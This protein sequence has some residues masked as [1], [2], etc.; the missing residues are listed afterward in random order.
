[1]INDKP[2][3]AVIGG[4]GNLGAAIATGLA[5]AGYPIVI[6][7]RDAARAVSAAADMSAAGDVTGAGNPG[8]AEKGDIVILA[9]PFAHQ[10]ATLG[11]I[12][13]ALEGKLVVETTVPLVPPKV[14]RVQLPAEGSAAVRAQAMLGDGVTVTSA[15]HT[16]SAHALTDGTASGDVLVFGDKR[17]A[18]DRVVELVDALGLRGIHGGGLAN[19]AAAE[20]MTSVLIFVNRLYGAG[21]AGLAITGDV[22]APRD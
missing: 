8:A 17:A 2:T 5:K 12:R 4:T 1:M 3:I 6:G 11:A 15:F 20:A 21:G 18:R 14:A 9:V 10:E 13:P 19:S 22:G 16:V 7:S